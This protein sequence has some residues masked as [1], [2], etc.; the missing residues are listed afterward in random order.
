MQTDSI[1]KL[2]TR[3]EACAIGEQI[4]APWGA[5]G[6]LYPAVIVAK[7]DASQVHVAFLDGDEG[8]AMIKDLMHG[9]LGVGNQVCVNY[10]G[11]GTYYTGT[12]VKV[13][14]TALEVDYD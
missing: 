14:G 7:I 13:V 4:W 6:F 1:S 11:Q 10:K 8:A 3:T 5:D 9:S 12:I 2:L